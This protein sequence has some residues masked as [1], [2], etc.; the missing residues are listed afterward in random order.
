M[1]DSF[2]IRPRSSRKR[3]TS[4]TKWQ[5]D[6]LISCD[7][8]ISYHIMSLPQRSLVC[9]RQWSS[10]Y[11]VSLMSMKW[12]SS[13]PSTWCLR[14]VSPP[15]SSSFCSKQSLVWRNSM[16]SSSSNESYL[17]LH[18]LVCWVLIVVDHY[19]LSSYPSL[20]VPAPVPVVVSFLLFLSL[21]PLFLLLLTLFA[22]RANAYGAGESRHHQRR[23]RVAHLLSK[24]HT[25][26]CVFDEQRSVII[27][28]NHHQHIFV[29]SP[30]LISHLSVVYQHQHPFLLTDVVQFCDFLHLIILNDVLK[31]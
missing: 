22:L 4:E 5:C 26:F 17:I 13:M 25:K 21:L 30:S 29:I 18:L 31:T 10:H 2:R 14:L 1:R 7:V 6:G 11:R 19:L 8:P 9:Y 23:T 27:E 28:P 3:D 15:F 12:L 24:H 20:F 16:A